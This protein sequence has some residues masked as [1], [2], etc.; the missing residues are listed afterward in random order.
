MDQ[1]PKCP[2]YRLIE[3]I[4]KK[5][6]SNIY[7]TWIPST[8]IAGAYQHSFNTCLQCISY[9]GCRPTHQIPVQCWASIAAHCWFNA[10]QS[11]T[12][13]EQHGRVVDI[14]YFCAF[15]K[16]HLCWYQGNILCNLVLIWTI[17]DKSLAQVKIILCSQQTIRWSFTAGTKTC[18]C[19]YLHNYTQKAA[20]KVYY[21]YSW[22]Y[23]SINI[24]R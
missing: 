14:R 9:R 13:K 6:T 3:E 19:I 12:L 16:L 22:S 15:Q 7:S 10:G 11:D 8:T 20:Y 21:K 1:N 18:T 2:G 23:P 4:T 24:L 5:T 17:E